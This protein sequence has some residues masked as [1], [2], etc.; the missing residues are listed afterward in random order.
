MTGSLRLLVVAAHPDDESLGLGGVLARYKAEGVETYL[1]TAT[2]GERGWQG[3]A[4]E[5]PGIETLGGIRERE[6]REATAVLG[7]DDV[8]ILDYIDGDL[9][10]ADPRE[11]IPRISSYIRRIRPQIVVT[12]SPDGAYGHPDHIAI[13]QF[14]SAAIVHANGPDH[15]SS[16]LPPHQVDKYYYSVWDQPE[17][18]F[19]ESIFGNLVM[20]VDGEMRSSVPW[21]SWSITTCID[22]KKYWRKTQA[23]VLC[24]RSQLET[25]PGLLDLEP[26]LNRELWG[27]YNFVRVFSLVN[28]GRALEVD[29]FEGLRD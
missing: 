17:I 11:I 10:Q 28:G 20:E 12:F 18:E 8:Q 5:N 25:I 29:L 3:P 1:V 19:Y 4:E 23:A 6:L 21:K 2:R 16:T 13:S 27:C 7:L 15:N 22:T 24:H 26:E 9:D 14:T